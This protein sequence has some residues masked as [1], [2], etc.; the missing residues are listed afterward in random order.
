MSVTA[1]TENHKTLRNVKSA[2]ADAM[3]IRIKKETKRALTKWIRRANSKNF[4]K[5]ILVDDIVSLGI[6]LIE[7]HHIEQLQNSSMT[8]KDRFDK[9]RKEYAKKIGRFVGPDEFLGILMAK[10][11]QEEQLHE[12]ENV[13]STGGR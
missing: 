12:K 13:A 9:E 3:P 11:N 1:Q 6:N 8:N 2:K 7:T 5:R 10:S 4:G